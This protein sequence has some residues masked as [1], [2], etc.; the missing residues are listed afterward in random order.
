VRSQAI[1]DGADG[2]ANASVEEV[3]DCERY[4]I[5]VAAV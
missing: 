3:G 1:D 2:E 5:V 4:E